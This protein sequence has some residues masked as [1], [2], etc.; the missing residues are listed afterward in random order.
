MKLSI[1][2]I[3][4]VFLYIDAVYLS[5]YLKYTHIHTSEHKFTVAQCVAHT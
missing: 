3:K 4:K 5:I 2:D 1:I